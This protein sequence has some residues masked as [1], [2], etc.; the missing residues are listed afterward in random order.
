M[1]FKVGD[2]SVHP[3]HGVGE[4]IAIEAKLFGE[5]EKDFYVVKIARSGLT[6]MVATDAAARLGLRRV[7]SRKR[8]KEVLETL[9]SRELHVTSKPWNR[10]FRAYTTMIN[11]GSIDDVAKVLCDL[12]RIRIGKDLSFGERG[13][14]EKARGLLVNELAIARRCRTQHIEN[15]IDQLLAEKTAPAHVSSA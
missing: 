4:V 9:R 8:A 5:I 10:R 7:I 3:H 11:S 13:L 12:S 2:M 14:L 15:E 1:N 6:V